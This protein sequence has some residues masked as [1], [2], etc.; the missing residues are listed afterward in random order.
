MRYS[1]LPALALLAAGCAPAQT[2]SPAPARLDKAKLEALL[3]YV[4][5]FRGK[6]DM[7]IGDPK[8]SKNLP[9]YSEVTVH[10]SYDAGT[11]DDLYLVSADGQTIIKG[12]AY[13]LGRN[14]FQANLDKVTLKDDPG[15]GPA[16]APVTIVEFGDFECPDCKSE[17]PLLREAVPL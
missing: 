12:T 8:P 5:V 3:R 4:D 1:V 10:L 15:F 14:P 9:G 17:A 13:N 11:R 6:V 7:T 2:P 16:N